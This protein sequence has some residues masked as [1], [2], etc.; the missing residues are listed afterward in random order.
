VE[1]GDGA[2][3]AVAVLEHLV[4]E[5]DV[6]ALVRE[7]QVLDGSHEVGVRVLD[8]V[9]AD[10]LRRE[11]REERAVGLGSASHVEEAERAQI[12]VR[13]PRF[14]RSQPTSGARTA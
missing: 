5:D 2:H 13:S 7:G 12:V 9:H 4:A 8:R 6:E 3:R 1:L 11:R 10:V 14:P